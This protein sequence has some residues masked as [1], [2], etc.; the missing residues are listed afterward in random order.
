MLDRQPSS[1]RTPARPSTPITYLSRAPLPATIGCTRSTRAMSARLRQR[2]GPRRRHQRQGSA[3]R[4]R[5]THLHAQRDLEDD[6]I[7]TSA[8]AGSAR[9]RACRS[10]RRRPRLKFHRFLRHHRVSGTARVPA[11]QLAGNRCLDRRGAG[12]TPH[13]VRLLGPVIRPLLRFIL[14]VQRRVDDAA[15]TPTRGR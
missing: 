2:G 12:Q 4:R 7:D 6:I 1:R 5:Q 8:L 13:P 14:A 11:A 10:P 15:G 3:H 9:R